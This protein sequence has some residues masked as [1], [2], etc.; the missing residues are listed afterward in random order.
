MN[1]NFEYSFKG[2][3]NNNYANIKVTK[4]IPLI[5]LCLYNALACGIIDN[6]TPIHSSPPIITDGIKFVSS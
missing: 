5:V 2:D 4:L 3:Y 6:G 1:N